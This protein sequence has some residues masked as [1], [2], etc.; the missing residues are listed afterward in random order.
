M[1]TKRKSKNIWSVITIAL[2]LLYVLFLIVPLFGLIKSSFYVEGQGFSLAYFKRFFGES[3]YSQTLINSLLVTVATTLACAVVAFPL[4][5]FMTT[6]KIKGSSFIQILI[7]ISSM[8]PPFIGAYS[9]VLLLG[10]SGV[11][12]KSLRSIGITGISIYGFHGIL[13]V[14]TLQMVPLIYMYLMGAM[15][16][17]DK[18]LVEAAENLG[19]T[20][21]KRIMKVF[22][23]LLIP[24]ILSASLLVFM[25]AF[26]D[27]GTPMLIGE[28]YQT[29]PVMIYN[30]F[31]GEIGGDTAFA[32]AISVVVIIMAITIFLVQKYIAE[33]KAFSMSA[34]HPI[35]AKKES[36]I[37]NIIAHVYVY[38]YVFISVAPLLYV[39]YTSFRKTRGSIFVK[40]LSLDS[41]KNAFSRLGTSITST[42]LLALIAIII[43]LIIGVLIAYVA[44]KRRNNMSQTL[45]VLSMLPYIVPGSVMGISLLSTFSAKPLLLSGT[46]TIMII[47]FVIRRL[48]YTI[49]S[50]VTAL[51]QIS[52]SIEEAAENLGATP[53]KSFTKIVLPMMKSGVISGAILSW[54]YIL[55]E[56]STSIL[57]Y[58][59]KTKTMTVSIYTEVLRGNY[60]NAAA[61]ATILIVLTVISLMLFFKVSGKKEISM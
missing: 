46:A 28:G 17:I 56:L 25:R 12:T 9:W 55:S 26:A 41:Y 49:R 3:Y 44:V 43:I 2:I 52:P 30:Q 11:I 60:G 53:M 5:Y 7:L 4:A 58:S 20:G 19:M 39:I 15:K 32:A 47:A 48:P 8:S 59:P 40:G 45:D 10:R 16:N 50:S 18:S 51:Y 13:L 36:G 54:I 23:P 35:E 27:F 38:L 1:Q 61:L 31:V 29:V 21:F 33:K 34:L 42:F 22:V 57:L 6:V 24:T 37:K 14:L